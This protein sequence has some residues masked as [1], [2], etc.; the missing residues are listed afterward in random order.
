VNED[1]WIEL[2]AE[3]LFTNFSYPAGQKTAR[4][5]FV[6]AWKDLPDDIRERIHSRQLEKFE[7]VIASMP[8]AGTL[9]ELAEL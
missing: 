8:K 3:F 6:R 5:R 7:A 2:V 4:R 1:E 9:E